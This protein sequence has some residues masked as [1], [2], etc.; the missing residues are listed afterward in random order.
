[1]G[2]GGREHEKTMHLIVL[3]HASRVTKFNTFIFKTK[4]ENLEVLTCTAR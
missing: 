2:E 3:I 4:A 1:M